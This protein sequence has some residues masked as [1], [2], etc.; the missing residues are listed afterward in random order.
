[1]SDTAVE[2][3]GP[4]PLLLPPVREV[5]ARAS[6]AS[7][8][9]QSRPLP[10][11]PKR[12]P[13][14]A[15]RTETRPVPAYSGASAVMAYAYTLLGRPYVFGRLDCSGLTMLAWARVG[16]RLPHNAAAQWRVVAHVTRAQLQPGDLV[17]YASL[18]HVALYVGG[19][20]VIHAPHTG[21]VVQVASVDIMPP[22]G[23]GRPRR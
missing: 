1:M 11:V 12:R 3:V 17:F 5:A 13:A 7:A 20:K 10:E 14:T 19:G 4:A 2:A 9:Q 8:R 6:R 18:G 22:Y 23:Y 15:R 16:V 21:T